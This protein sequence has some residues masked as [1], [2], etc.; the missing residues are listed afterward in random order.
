M[1]TYA[2]RC[3]CGEEFDTF[4]KSVPKREVRDAECASC[5]ERAPR[6]RE[7]EIREGDVAPLNAASSSSVERTMAVAARVEDGRTVYTDANGRTQAV[8][9]AADVDRWMR[10]DNQLGKPRMREVV[11]PVTGK[12]VWATERKG[13]IKFDATGEQL[14]TGPVLRESAK[15]V[16]L[17]GQAPM[18]TTTGAPLNARG[19]LARN[20]ADMPLTAPDPITGRRLTVRDCWGDDEGPTRPNARVLK[21]LEGRE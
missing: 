17:K 21:Q 11:N 13:G 4:L 16:Q 19:V 8:R 3:P 15:L 18:R 20:P 9:T 5:G 2:F 1:P 10:G 6:D 7:R 12:K 14:D